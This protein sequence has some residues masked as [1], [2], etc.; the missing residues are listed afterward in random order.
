MRTS[1]WSN[2]TRAASSRWLIGGALGTVLIVAA[3]CSS[4]GATSATSST[5]ASGSS[6]HS[7]GSA[8]VTVA[9]VGSLGDAL[10][11]ASGRTLYRFTLDTTGKSNC[12][13]TCASLWAPLTVPAG[14]THVLAGTGVGNGNLGTITRS[15]GSLQVTFKGMPLYTYTGDT[16]NGV[17]TGQGSGGTWFVV[18]PSAQSTATGASSAT[19]TTTKS[20]GGYGY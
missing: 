7:S 4:G 1:A 20:S 16:K 6:N 3:A 10:V 8:V 13:G 5:V 17:A 9:S 2:Q 14:T 11:N 15:D 18:T 12:T 19:T